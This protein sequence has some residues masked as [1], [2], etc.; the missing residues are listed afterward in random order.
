VDFVHEGSVDIQVYHPLHKYDNN[1]P[2]W[3]VTEGK[4]LFLMPEEFSKYSGHLLEVRPIGEPSSSIPIDQF[5]LSD[6]NY[7]IVSPSQEYSLNIISCD[8]S[9]I[10]EYHIGLS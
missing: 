6:K 7:L 1:R 2:E 10:A 5:I 3:L 8:G 9:I 4:G